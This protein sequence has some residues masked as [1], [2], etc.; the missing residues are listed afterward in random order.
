MAT[1]A[2]LLGGQAK[3]KLRL[4]LEFQALASGVKGLKVKGS[5]FWILGFRV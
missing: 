4:S 1:N 3:G 2:P 5:G